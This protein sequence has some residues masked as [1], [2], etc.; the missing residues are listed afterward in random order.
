MQREIIC[1]QCAQKHHL[2]A[3]DKAL[4]FQ[5]RRIELT[6]RKPE[7]H[8]ITVYAGDSMADLKVEKHEELATIV[9]DRCGTALPDGSPA[10]AV[11]TWRGEEPAEWESEYGVRK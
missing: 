6:V 1:Q 8:G 2:H 7:K 3:E 9:C 5:Q 11:T 4:G 10:I